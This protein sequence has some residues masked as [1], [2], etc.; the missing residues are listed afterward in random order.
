MPTDWNDLDRRLASS[1]DWATAARQLQYSPAESMLGAP[2]NGLIRAIAD[3]PSND[4]QP[5]LNVAC[6]WSRVDMSRAVLEALRGEADPARSERLAW[7][8]KSVLATEHSTEAIAIVL[9]RGH[10]VDVRIWLAE[11]LERLV[12]GGALSWSDLDRVVDELESSHAAGLR[13]RAASLFLSLPWR[14]GIAGRLAAMLDD[15]DSEVVAAAAHTL[16]MRPAAASTIAPKVIE[17]L[18]NHRDAWVRQI[19]SELF[20]AIAEYVK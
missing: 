20:A 15:P 1:G 19:A 11:G 14:D 6:A 9:D 7:L 8:L 12:L 18:R 10:S 4:D 2:P 5:L 3:G 16:A 17:Q 13:A